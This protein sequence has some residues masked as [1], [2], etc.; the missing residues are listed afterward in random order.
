MGLMD[1]SDGLARDLPR[2]LGSGNTGLGADIRLNATMLQPELLRFTAERGCDAAMFAYCGGE[3][4]AL[5]GT[6]PAYAWP[7]LEQWMAE[8]GHAVAGIGTVLRSDI[9]LNGIKVEEAGFDHF[10]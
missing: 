6:C 4:Y 2:L 9:R 1:V 7:E 10:A 3:D 5:V 8:G